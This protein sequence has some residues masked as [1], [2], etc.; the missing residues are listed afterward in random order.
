MR[1]EV[2]EAAKTNSANPSHENMTK[3]KEAQAKLNT[4]YEKEQAELLQNK[5]DDIEKAASNK[6][7]AV[8]WKTVNEISGRKS[9]NTAK[10]KASS[11]EERLKLWKK[12]FEDLLGTA[13]KIK[14]TPITP[15]VSTLLN[16]KTGRFE[17]KELIKAQKQ[18]QYGKSCGL[19][20]IPPE[21]W[22]NEEIREILLGFTNDVYEQREIES[23]VDGCLL[24]FP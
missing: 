6:K 14:D 22:K 10:L 16:I 15:V 9:A 19:D 2:Q 1:K 23:W 17:M 4:T 20:D 7:S 8:A 12:H 5:I 3:F 18:V 24:P 21:V 13:P 11:E